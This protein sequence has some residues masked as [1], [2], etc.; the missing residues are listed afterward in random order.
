MVGGGGRVTRARARCGAGNRR[1]DAS[2]ARPVACSAD[3]VGCEAAWRLVTVGCSSVVSDRQWPSLCPGNCFPRCMGPCWSPV[4]D[5]SAVIQRSEQR[6]A[7][8]G[9]RATCAEERRKKRNECGSRSCAKIQICQENRKNHK[10]IF[11]I[12]FFGRLRT[13]LAAVQIGVP[14]NAVPRH[15]S[16]S[17]DLALTGT[18]RWRSVLAGDDTSSET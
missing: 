2:R 8:R 11:P 9:E 6:G 3:A 16:I 14:K 18:L 7:L 12:F 13:I 4:W 17:P 15:S 1:R 5:H 10:L